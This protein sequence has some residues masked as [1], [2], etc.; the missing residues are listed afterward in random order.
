MFSELGTQTTIEIQCF[1]D[2][3]VLG[4]I[5][6]CFCCVL[7]LGGFGA[8]DKKNIGFTVFSELGTKK[9]WL[10]CVFGAQDK[11]NI[12]TTKSETPGSCH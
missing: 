3:V 5:K 10:Y 4:Q 6:R 7:F 2:F 8:E 12:R 1:R 11:K 9:Q